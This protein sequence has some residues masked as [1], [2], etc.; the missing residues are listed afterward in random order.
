MNQLHVYDPEL[1]HPSL[2]HSV[3]AVLD[4][5][6][7]KLSYPKSNIPRRAT[8]EEEI[9]DAVFVSH[10]C[11]DLTDA[12]VGLEVPRTLPQGPPTPGLA[13]PHSRCCRSSCAPPAWPES[14]RGTRNIPSVCS[15]PSQQRERAGAARSRTR[16]CRGMRGQGRCRCLGRTSRGTAG[17]GACTCLGGRGGRRRSGTSTLCKPPVGHPAA[18]V[19]PGQVRNSHHSL[20][21]VPGLIPEHNPLVGSN[22]HG[23]T[24]RSPKCSQEGSPRQHRVGGMSLA[25]WTGIMSPLMLS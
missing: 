11:Y 9:L 25:S 20:C 1:F 2:T 8:F 13:S 18:T 12:K 22:E 3:L 19:T 10:R 16:S 17:R 4:G 15:S 14:G 24:W 21:S 7:L 23:G 6:T 5:S